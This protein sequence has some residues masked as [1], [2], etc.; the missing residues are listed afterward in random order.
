MDLFSERVGRV[1]QLPGSMSPF[2]MALLLDERGD[3]RAGKVYHDA[4][5]HG[6]SV[7]DAYCNL[8]ILESK[9]G[10]TTKAFDCF[11]KSLKDD[12]RH[13]ESHYN[14]GNLYFEAGDLKL[15]RTHFELAIEIDPEFSNAYF[16]L[17]L[18]HAL[19]EDFSSAAEAFQRFIEMVPEDESAR[20]RELLTNLRQTLKPPR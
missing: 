7:A 2:D 4:I 5:T 9:A 10:R 3:E 20:A 6:D 14:L 18:V 15:A 11:T 13:L 19:N 17:G 12:P 8:G 1:L 16:N